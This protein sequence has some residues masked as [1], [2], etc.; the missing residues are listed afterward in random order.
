MRNPFVHACIRFPHSSWRGITKNEISENLKNGSCEGAVVEGTMAP[1]GT[2][3]TTL[4]PVATV[5]LLV[6]KEIKLD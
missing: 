1:S 2:W 3:W 4:G 5:V 6:S